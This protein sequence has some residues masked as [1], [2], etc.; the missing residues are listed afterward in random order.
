[1]KLYCSSDTSPIIE[2]GLNRKDHWWIQQGPSCSFDTI[3]FIFPQI[4]FWHCI[5]VAST[6]AP[7]KPEK[8]WIRQRRGL[9][10]QLCQSTPT[11]HWN[12][13]CLESF[14]PKKLFFWS[15]NFEINGL[16]HISLKNANSNVIASLDSFPMVTKTSTSETDLIYVLSDSGEY[17]SSFVTGN[18][19]AVCTCMICT[20][21][22]RY[23]Y[24]ASEITQ[25]MWAVYFWE[26]GWKVFM[27]P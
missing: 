15:W 10:L 27:N 11:I 17:K 19:N 25:I 23:F 12:V 7:S 5:V 9:I 22:R 16:I 13:A 21:H 3:S 6:P 8:F 18:N 14:Q 4:I 2:N 26:I 24:K 20:T 1:M